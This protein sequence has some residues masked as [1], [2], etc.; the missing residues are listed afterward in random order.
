MQEVTLV[1]VATCSSLEEAYLYKGALEQANIPCFIQGE[2]HR[3]MLGM[4]GS[5]IEPGLMVPSNR[6]DE[7][8]DVLHSV[9]EDL[10]NAYVEE[11]LCA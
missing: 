2:H 7:A 8:I 4:L 10:E 9:K 1:L 3:S 11:D 6:E 5:Y